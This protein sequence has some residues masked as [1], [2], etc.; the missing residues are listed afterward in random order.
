MITAIKE[1]I[2]NDAIA[3]HEAAIAKLKTSIAEREKRIKSI[4]WAFP[5]AR[6]A[7]SQQHYRE[8]LQLELLELELNGLKL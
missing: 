6:I 2:A 4:K 8:V 5:D 3:G 7:M 1:H